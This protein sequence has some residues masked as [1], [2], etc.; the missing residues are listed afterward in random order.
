MNFIA[1]DAL[2]VFESV[3]FYFKNSLQQM[4][5]RFGLKWVKTKTASIIGQ[6]ETVIIHNLVYCKIWHG[7]FAKKWT[8]FRFCIFEVEL[9]GKFIH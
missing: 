4:I 1:V 8:I 7:K 9:F 2:F 6:E 5:S 3:V